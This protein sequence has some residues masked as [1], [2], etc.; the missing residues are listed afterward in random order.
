MRTI[1]DHILD[2]ASNSIT[3]KADEVRLAIT[4]DTG[5][6][7]IVFV[8][9]DNGCG[10]TAEV[11]RQVFDP[12]F[13]TRSHKVRRFGLG[14]PFLRENTEL[15]GGG[16]VLA[17]RIGAG[18]TVCATFHADNIDCLPL[19]DIPS[20]LFALLI[21][22]PAVSWDIRRKHDNLVYTVKTSE[23]RSV[24]TA[25]ELTDPKVQMLLL[26]FLRELEQGVVGNEKL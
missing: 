13:T 6:H 19:G 25:D 5:R 17:S 3:A 24:F 8:V 22:D 9:R 11:Q 18:T 23:L 12:F 14:L 20:T 4:Q 1:A 2:I 15:T 21:A 26:G 10:M 7:I 16:V